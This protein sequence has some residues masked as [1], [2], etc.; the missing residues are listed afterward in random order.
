M[1]SVYLFCKQKG[2]CFSPKWHNGK[3]PH[4]P[5]NSVLLGQKD[6]DGEPGTEE[7]VGTRRKVSE[8]GQP[9][10]KVSSKLCAAFIQSICQSPQMST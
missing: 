9:K 6:R 8:K 10:R 7:V 3:A 4:Q 2:I 1:C 5:G